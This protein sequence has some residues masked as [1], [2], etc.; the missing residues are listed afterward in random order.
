MARAGARIR[1]GKVGS[2]P[3]FFGPSSLAKH[4]TKARNCKL[5]IAIIYIL[6]YVLLQKEQAMPRAGKHTISIVP[7][8]GKYRGR[9]LLTEA[10]LEIYLNPVERTLFCLF[11]AHPEGILADNLLL[12]WQEL[13]SIYA[14]ESLYD[15]PSLRDDALESLCNESKRVFYS[16]ISRIKKKFVATLGARK[17]SGYYIKRY[18]NGLYRTLATLTVSDSHPLC[19]HYGRIY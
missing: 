3:G 18:P 7:G 1:K 11:L 13:C 2:K 5:V 16:N 10:G 8:N 14:R 12:H 15:D 19:K 6:R 9:I 17:A 4:S